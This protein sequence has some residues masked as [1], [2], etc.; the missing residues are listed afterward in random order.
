MKK[1]DLPMALVVVAAIAGICYL[2]AIDADTTDLMLIIITLIGGVGAQQ[3]AGLKQNTN[4]NMSRLLDMLERKH[5][6]EAPAPTPPTIDGEV[7]E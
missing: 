6:A 4:G 2:T 3:L 7:K 5:A 1:I